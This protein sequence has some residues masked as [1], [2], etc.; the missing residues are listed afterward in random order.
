M[1]E[2]PNQTKTG[3]QIY[4]KLDLYSDMKGEVGSDERNYN[5]KSSKACH[6]SSCMDKCKHEYLQ[7]RASNQM[8]RDF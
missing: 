4:L 1:Q 8:T 2:N 6:I 5:L 3:L 7:L